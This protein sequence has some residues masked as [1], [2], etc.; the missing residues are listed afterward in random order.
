MKNT[1]P[2]KPGRLL[3]W[4]GLPSI[5]SRLCDMMWGWREGAA[6]EKV[7]TD[8]SEGEDLKLLRL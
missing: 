8:D 7:W 6:G 4:W 5:N 2:P 3:P 1:P